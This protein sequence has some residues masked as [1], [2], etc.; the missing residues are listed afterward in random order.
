[1]VAGEVDSATAGHLDAVFREVID[2]GASQVV[3]DFERVTFV[4]SAGLSVLIGAHRRSDS[5]RLLRGNRV[6]DRLVELTGLEMLYGT[7]D[8][9]LTLPPS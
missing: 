7:G 6:V 5:F 1:M 2:A 4:S 3:A 8:D 9:T